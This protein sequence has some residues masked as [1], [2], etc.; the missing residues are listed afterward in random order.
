MIT[1]AW[2]GWKLHNVICTC[3]TKHSYKLTTSTCVSYLHVNECHISLFAILCAVLCTVKLKWK[4][5][6][7]KCDVKWTEAKYAVEWM[8]KVTPCTSSSQWL[9]HTSLNVLWIFKEVYFVSND[10]SN[11]FCSILFWY[12][13]PVWFRITEHFKFHLVIV[14]CHV[15]NRDTLWLFHSLTM[16]N[17]FDVRTYT[18]CNTRSSSAS[19]CFLSGRG[20]IMLTRSIKRALPT[21][22]EEN[23]AI[24]T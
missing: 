12:S 6:K 20:S 18:N 14:N 19:R 23:V 1:W 9:S 13:L 24:A 22:V 17:H 3:S 10:W 11:E 4:D 7:A 8:E 15:Y 2:Q 5:M 16:Q 21:S